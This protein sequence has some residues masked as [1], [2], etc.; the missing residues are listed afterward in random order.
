VNEKVATASFVGHYF[1]GAPV[2]DI[3]FIIFMACR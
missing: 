3:E 2:F 1:I